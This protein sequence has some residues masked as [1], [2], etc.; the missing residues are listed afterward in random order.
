MLDFLLGAMQDLV[1]LQPMGLYAFS[2]GIVSMK[3]RK[4]FMKASSKFLP[5]RHLKWT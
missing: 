5:A 3:A 1:T 2:Y 4:A